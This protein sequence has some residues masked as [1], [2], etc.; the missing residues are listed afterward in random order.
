[1]HHVVAVARHGVASEL[2]TDGELVSITTTEGITHNNLRV[3]FGPNPEV[4]GR[5][6][7]GIIDDVGIWRRALDPADIALIR[8]GGAGK[9]LAELTGKMPVAPYSLTGATHLLNRSFQ[10]RFSSGNELAFSVLTSPKIRCPLSNWTMQGVPAEAPP[11]QYPFTD[12]QAT[13]NTQRFYRM[14][15]P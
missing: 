3:C 11:G 12:P 10:F 4:T 1:M 15:S 6:G 9:S 14:R 8:N 7:E 5:S 13:N 2:W